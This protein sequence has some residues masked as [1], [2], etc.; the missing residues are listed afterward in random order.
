MSPQPQSVAELDAG[1]PRRRC[2][3]G[4][5]IRDQQGRILVVK[6]S[7]RAGWLL[8]GGLVEARETPANALRRETVEEV[9]IMPTLVRL[10]CIDLLPPDKGFSESVHFLFECER[11]HTDGNPCLPTDGTEILEARFLIPT[12]AMELLIAPIRRRLGTV[13][14]GGHGY[15]EDGHFILPFGC[16]KDIS[17]VTYPR[18]A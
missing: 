18:S 7:Y 11:V 15:L 14:D 13:L 8:P 17:L 4:G 3:A 16:G 12:Q 2:S 10:L 5:I 6:P 1:F 9:G